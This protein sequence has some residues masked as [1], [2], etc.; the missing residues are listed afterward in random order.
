MKIFVTG[1]KSFLSKKFREHAKH[2]FDIYNMPRVIK[3]KEINDFYLKKKIILKYLKDRKPTHL[4][5]FAGCRKNESEKNKIFAK[6]SIFIITKNLVQS[7]NKYNKNILFI[8]IST[9]HVFSGRSKF[10]KENNIKYLKPSTNLG[11][12]KIKSEFFIKNNCKK[13]IIIRPSVVMDDP[14]Q[15]SFVHKCVKKKHK[16]NL[17]SNVFFTPISSKD[18]SRTLMKILSKNIFNKIIHCSGSKR[19]SRYHFYSDVFG[20]SNNFLPVKINNK[21]H[22][23]DLSMSSTLSQSLLNI[24]FLKYKSLIK[25]IKILIQKNSKNKI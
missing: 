17:Y 11:F 25:D 10:Y 24:N 22:P 5:H 21:S 16:I 12:Y 4:I 7:I 13:W 2:V 3:K 20:K 23:P 15:L 6:K 14:R 9:D 1:K 18:L 19:V 8:Y